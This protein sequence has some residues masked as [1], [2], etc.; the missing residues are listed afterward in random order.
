MCC[1]G[2]QYVAANH[3]VNDSL[4]TASPTRA[5]QMGI[6]LVPDRFCSKHCPFE[7]A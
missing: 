3:S 7:F 2:F 6:L 4:F 5:G 1:E